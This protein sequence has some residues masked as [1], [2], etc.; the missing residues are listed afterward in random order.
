MKETIIYF[1]IKEDNRI[2]YFK[3]VNGVAFKVLEI[4]ELNIKF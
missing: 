2:V 1:C 4:L 3:V